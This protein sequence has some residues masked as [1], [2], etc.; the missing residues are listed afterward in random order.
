MLA[1][2]ELVSSA[3]Q[4][5]LCSRRVRFISYIIL[6]ETGKFTFSFFFFFFPESHI[7]TVFETFYHAFI[8][9]LFSIFNLKI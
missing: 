7:Q 1:K 8:I 2:Q 6:I 4:T 3:I 9:F 5:L